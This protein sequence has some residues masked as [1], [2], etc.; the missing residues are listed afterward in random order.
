MNKLSFSFLVVLLSAVSCINSPKHQNTANSPYFNIKAYFESEVN[1][2]N[3]EH[4]KISKTVNSNGKTESK[5][6][7]DTI[8]R[9]EL[10]V[11]INSN[12]N[13]PAWNKSYL[14][15]KSD[16]SEV[17]KAIDTTLKTREISIIKHPD[18]TIKSI[19]ILNT[20]DNELYELV[21]KLE[22]IPNKFYKIER[23]QQS[24]LLK[25]SSFVVEGKFLN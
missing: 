5:V 15:N 19:S 8:W 17:Y 3:I 18:G 11:F 25:E 13:K 12:I 14:V 9:S 23:K 20:T 4:P 21:E 16:T 7:Q 24:K 6:I 10:S 22:Y 2:L 1:R